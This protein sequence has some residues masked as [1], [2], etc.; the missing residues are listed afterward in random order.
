MTISSVLADA[1][2]ARRGTAAVAASFADFYGIVELN[3]R[4]ASVLDSGDWDAWP[5]FFEDDCTYQVLPRENHERDFPLALLSFESKGMLKDRV[6]GIKETLFYDPYYQRHLIGM[7]LITH[8]DESVIETETNYAVLRTKCE[9]MSDVY[10]TGRYLDR[11]RRTPHGLRFE[12]R[13]CVY[14]SEM[15]PNSIIYPI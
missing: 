2:V 8:L 12:S 6:Y 5:E 3:V 15:V 11:I 13:I 10:N 14:D 4:Y 9:Q 1:R 7:P